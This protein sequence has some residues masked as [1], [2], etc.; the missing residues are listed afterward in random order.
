VL[1]GHTQSIRAVAVTD[2]GRALSGSSDQTVRAWDLQSGRT[3]AVFH[4]DAA[5]V[6]VGVAADGRTIV[7]G[8]SAGQVHFLRLEGV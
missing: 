8:D 1:Q 5:F 3:I 7:A 6:M 2:D 4:G